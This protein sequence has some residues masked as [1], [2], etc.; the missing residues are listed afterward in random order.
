MGYI[1]GID[2]GSYEIKETLFEGSLGRYAFKKS[3]MH[4]SRWRGTIDCSPINGKK[5]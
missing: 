2:V 1:V 3:L 4:C 5:S